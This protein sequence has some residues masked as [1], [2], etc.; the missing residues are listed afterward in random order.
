M[1]ISYAMRCIAVHRRAPAEPGRIN[2]DC[3]VCSKRCSCVEHVII[4]L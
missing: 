4:T 2:V 1:D 3:S